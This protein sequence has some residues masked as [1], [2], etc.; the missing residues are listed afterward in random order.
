VEV[1]AVCC[2]TR[3]VDRLHPKSVG[4]LVLVKHNSYHLYES[5]ILPFDHPILL[6]S[7]GAENSCLI[8]YSSR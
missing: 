3:R 6:R 1:E 2:M 8:P 4:N 7:V 5:S